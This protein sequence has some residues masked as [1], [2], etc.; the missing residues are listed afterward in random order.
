MGLYGCLQVPATYHP[1]PPIRQGSRTQ[2]RSTSIPRIALP[3]APPLVSRQVSVFLHPGRTGRSVHSSNG[4]RTAGSNQ[5]RTS[6]DVRTRPG[7]SIYKPSWENTWMA[8]ARKRSTAVE[9]WLPPRC[10]PLAC[11]SSRKACDVIN[12]RGLSIRL[13]KISFLSPSGECVQ[14]RGRLC[15]PPQ[16]PSWSPEHAC[17]LFCQ[18]CAEPDDGYGQPGHR[19]AA[20]FRRKCRIRA[21]LSR[22]SAA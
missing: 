1:T 8:Y 17:L 5:T 21:A 19:K 12:P 7:N 6:L 10:L 14:G 11:P 13:R 20:V 22:P 15:R 2:I 9:G 3:A 4:S 18:R 16:A